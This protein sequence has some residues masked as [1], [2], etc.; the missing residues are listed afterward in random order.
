MVPGIRVPQ[1]QNGNAALSQAAD[2]L[3]G[4]SP[5]PWKFEKL[6]ASEIAAIMFLVPVNMAESLQLWN[7]LEAFL[8]NKVYFKSQMCFFVVCFCLLL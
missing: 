7:L 5:A 1:A 2:E 6:Q 3:P 8:F 4:F